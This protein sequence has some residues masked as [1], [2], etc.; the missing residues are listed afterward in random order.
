MTYTNDKT[1]LTNAYG[2]QK[3]RKKKTQTDITHSKCFSYRVR[4]NLQNR[5]HD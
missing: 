3:Q 4:S 5:W 2:K 1:S